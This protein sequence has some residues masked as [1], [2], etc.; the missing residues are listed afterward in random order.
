MVLIKPSCIKQSEK[1]AHL[2]ILTT[3][4]TLKDFNTRRLRMDLHNTTVQK[5]VNV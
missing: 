3:L 2:N 4:S 5:G 1:Y